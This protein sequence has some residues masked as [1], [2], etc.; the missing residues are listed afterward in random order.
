[1]I[2]IIYKQGHNNQNNILMK[3]MNKYIALLMI[4]HKIIIETSKLSTKKINLY[5]KKLEE[6]NKYNL[7]YNNKSNHITINNSIINFSPK[8]SN[9][10]NNTLK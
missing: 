10:S 7:D 4:S 6:T 8:T 1:M 9:N 5:K 2:S 3:N